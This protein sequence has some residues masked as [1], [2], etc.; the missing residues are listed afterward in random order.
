[1]DERTFFFLKDTI[2]GQYYTGQNNELFNFNSSAVYHN[3]KNALNGCKRVIQSWEFQKKNMEYWIEKT[4]TKGHPT[5]TDD[6]LKTDKSWA[7]KQKDDVLKRE[8]LENWGIKIVS[9][10]VTC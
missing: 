9:S 5:D 10:K 2:T 1:M 6:Q 3:Q 8:K 7:K 4:K